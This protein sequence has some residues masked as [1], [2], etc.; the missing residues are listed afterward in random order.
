VHSFVDDANERGRQTARPI[1]GAT[2][3]DG[4]RFSRAFRSTRANGV[5]GTAR[6][7]RTD[8]FTGKGRSELCRRGKTVTTVWTRATMVS[9]AATTAVGDGIEGEGVSGDRA[10]DS[11]D[12]V[13]GATTSRRSVRVAERVRAAAANRAATEND[14]DADDEGWVR[15]NR[16]RRGRGRRLKRIRIRSH[17]ELRELGRRGEMRMMTPRERE[18]YDPRR[19]PRP[20]YDGVDAAGSLG[21]P[22]EMSRSSATPEIRHEAADRH[23]TDPFLEGFLDGFRSAALS[24]MTQEP[25]RGLSSVELEKH[26]PTRD[27][28]YPCGKAC[29]VCLEEPAHGSCVRELP[30]SHVYHRECI[31]RWF[32]LSNCC[33]T[34]RKPVRPDEHTP[35]IPTRD[36]IRPDL[37]SWGAYVRLVSR[38][39]APLT[40]A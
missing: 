3:E 39:N 33:P 38:I 24:R 8:T 21:I 28:G 32:D 26:A 14:V 30:C 36:Q 12:G 9:T 34:C 6:R 15:R 1:A 18:R 25:R 13:R 19:T 10:N 4:S 7:G 2:T 11:G 17:P 23:R 5:E 16:R 35:I 27:A 31:D 29:A 37:D 20:R 40:T 22:H